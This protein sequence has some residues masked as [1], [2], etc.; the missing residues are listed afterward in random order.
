MIQDRE[1][2]VRFKSP[3]LI[4]VCTDTHNDTW[5]DI[6]FTAFGG[7]IH[8]CLNEA[9]TCRMQPLPL[10]IHIWSVQLMRSL[11]VT[12]FTPQEL[13]CLKDPQQVL[14]G[15]GLMESNEETTFQ[16]IRL[17]FDA[18]AI[19]KICFDIG[20]YI[21]VAISYSG[22]GVMRTPQLCWITLVR[23]VHM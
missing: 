11:G 4:S 19:L 21:G 17:P 7:L 18:D 20:N 10:F 23:N 6:P 22:A 8:G 14:V 16:D 2:R 12:L 3:T 13:T 9:G 5:V 15:V 1:E